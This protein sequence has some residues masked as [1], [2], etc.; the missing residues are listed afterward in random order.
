MRVYNLKQGSKEWHD[1]RPLFFTASEAPVMMGYSGYCTRTELLDSKKSGIVE[2]I[3]SFTQRL[4]AKGHALEDNARSDAEA[5]IGEELFPM[6]GTETID[7]IPMLASFDGLTMFKDVNWEHK[8]MNQEL[9]D[10]LSMNVI[11]DAYH[12]QMEEQMMVS[13]AERTLFMAS[14]EIAPGN[15]PDH[16]WVWYESNPDLR[17]KI[18][19]G[20][21]QFEKDLAVH[22]VRVH[23]AKLDGEEVKDLPALLIKI[24]GDVKESNLEFYEQTAMAFIANIN[25]DLK[26]DQDFADAEKIV[27]FCDTSEKEIKA[28]KEEVLAQTASIDELFNSLDRISEKLRT[29]RLKLSKDVKAEKIKI[30]QFILSEAKQAINKHVNDINNNLK[31]VFIDHPIVNFDT[32]MKNK[33]SISSIH[34][35]VDQ[36]LADAKIIADEIASGYKVNINTLHEHQDYNDHQFLFNDL[37]TFI[38]RPSDSFSDLIN[39]RLMRYKEE[40]KKKQEAILEAER[41]KIRAEEK[42]KAEDAAALKL[43]EDQ[44]K[45]REDERKKA[46]EEQSANNAE[47]PYRPKEAPTSSVDI[48]SHGKSTAP[49]NNFQDM[50]AMSENPAAGIS[51]EDMEEVSRLEIPID[52]GAKVIHA[53]VILEAVAWFCEWGIDQRRAEAIVR[54]IDDGDAPNLSLSIKH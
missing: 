54:Q 12:P 20:W 1:L 22:E 51:T 25:T 37:Q 53:Q 19:L 36:V 39:L 2:D 41:E 11:P 18:I 35:A 34:S 16:L 50:N 33:R 47:K 24:T 44:D 40:E 52:E 38:D 3:D 4:Y 10:S 46:T 30:K 21:K 13:G 48:S 26:T 32:A 31:I 23:A 29:T 49:D 17:K 28:K 43:K 27:K 15:P 6:T 8:M 7:G 45:I 9:R 5:I 42:K 14:A